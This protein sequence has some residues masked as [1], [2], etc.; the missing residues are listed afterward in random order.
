MKESKLALHTVPKAIRT[1]ERNM[2][3]TSQYLQQLQKNIAGDGPAERQILLLKLVYEFEN[4]P[5][6]GDNYISD[7]SSPAQQWISR[8]GALL[9]RSGLSH[10]VTFKSLRGTSTQFWA[11]SRESF[12]QAMSEVIEEIKLELELEGRQEIGQV[13]EAGKE[14]NFFSDLKGIVED[15][16]SD[17]FLVDAYFDAAAFQ[18]YLSTSKNGRSIRIL[19]GRY[20][21]DLAACVSAFTAQTGEKVELRRSSSIHDR[22][23]FLDKSDCWI[24]GA[25]I[26][27]AGKK[28]TYLIPFAP[29][30]TQEKLAIYEDIWSLATPV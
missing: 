29:Q 11:L 15:A 22:V 1:A 5:D 18:A 4:A 19:C 2:S 10:A 13:Y 25:S 9:S 23:I 6:F 3:N 21:A 17:L 8:V 27:D 28:P 14:Y 26:K 16:S 20:A 30:L 7:A 12:R 24:V